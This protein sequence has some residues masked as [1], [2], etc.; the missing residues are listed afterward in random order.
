MKQSL[1]SKKPLLLGTN[2][3]EGFWVLLLMNK[4]LEIFPLK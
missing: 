3:D 4:L 1:Y 2:A